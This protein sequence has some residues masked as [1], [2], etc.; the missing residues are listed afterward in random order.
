MVNSDLGEGSRWPDFL[1]VGAMRS[2]S[3]SL[4]RYLDDHPEIFMATPKEVGYFLHNFN[5]G[6]DWYTAHF[7]N[8]GDNRKAGEATPSYMVNARAVSRIKQCV[9]EALLIVILREPVS[10][11][12]SHYWMRRERNR[13]SRSFSEVVQ[14][15]LAGVEELDDGEETGYLG[16][17]LYARHLSR[18]LE[19]FPRKQ[20][21]VTILEELMRDASAVYRGVCTALG[22]DPD[23]V[24]RGLGRPINS[25]VTFRS[26][27]VRTLARRLPKPLRRGVDRLNTR[28][29]AVYPAI[30]PS[31]AQQLAEFFSPHNRDLERIIGRPIPD[32]DRSSRSL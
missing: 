26:E 22:V 28:R 8:A 20:L 23:H 16:H 18:L 9:P 3:T 6:E 27:E 4:T 11:A 13:E 24:P 14:I 25:Y 12:Y 17:S 5:R 10:R 21:H 1:I 31:L 19:V 2:G 32:W 15:E 7:A 29:N 30:D